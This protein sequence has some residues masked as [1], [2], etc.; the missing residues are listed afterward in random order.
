MAYVDRVKLIDTLNAILVGQKAMAASLPVVIASDQS[1]VPISGAVSVTPSGTQDVAVLSVVPGVGATNL[2]KAEDAAAA[3]GDT[4][5]AALAMKMAVATLVVSTDGDY[6]VL[7]VDAQN[8]LW[9]A[10]QIAH[11]SP[12][13]GAPFRI[14]G[15]ARTTEMGAVASDDQVDALFDEFGKQ[16]IVSDA[17]PS[18]W[19]SGV[20][21]AITG[22]ADTEVIAAPGANL[23]LNITSIL[24]TNSHATVGT[25]VELKS[26][27]TVK[28]RGYAAALGG[29]F[30]ILFKTPLKLAVNVAFNAAN[31]TTGSSIYVSAAGFISGN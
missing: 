8:R 12:I 3:S 29:G 15:R 22:T 7:Q 16:I 1:A 30:L 10:G 23:Y 19:I 24:V 21:A 20:T 17:I 18:K 2:G 6:T 9:T 27:T 31:I 25:V 13:S 11:D 28:Q 4:G 14:G 5:I 26:A